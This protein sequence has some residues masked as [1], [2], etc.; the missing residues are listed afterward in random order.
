MNPH[1]F[2]EKH[3]WPPMNAD[4]RRW[5]ELLLLIGVYLR[6]SAAKLSSPRSRG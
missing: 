1:R 5:G 3:Y 4:E 6:S 2:T